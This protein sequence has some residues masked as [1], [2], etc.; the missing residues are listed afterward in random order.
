MYELHTYQRALFGALTKRV[1]VIARRYRYA[2]SGRYRRSPVHY[3]K[4]GG[5]RKWSVQESSTAEIRATIYS[6]RYRYV[7]RKLLQVKFKSG[8]QVLLKRIDKVYKKATRPLE[9]GAPYLVT[10]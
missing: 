9:P 5:N 10:C 2:K 1:V 7:E 3:T 6:E 8:H 4:C